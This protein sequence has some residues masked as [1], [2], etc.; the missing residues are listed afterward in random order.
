MLFSIPPDYYTSLNNYQKR[1]P[2]QKLTA[3]FV[4]LPLNGYQF[5][6]IFTLC[7]SI[8]HCNF[9]LSGYNHYLITILR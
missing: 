2:A 8:H 9:C 5:Y 3:S 6:F 4:P 1:R 7:V